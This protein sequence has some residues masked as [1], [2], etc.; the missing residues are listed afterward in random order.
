LS[1]T[2]L[3]IGGTLTLAAF[4][5]RL[6]SGLQPWLSFFLLIVVGA[7]TIVLRDLK[8]LYSLSHKYTSSKNEN[9]IAEDIKQLAT[10]SPKWIILV[11]QAAVFM[12]LV[13]LIG[14]FLP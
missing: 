8:T 9:S 12:S 13:L 11:S 6:A 10:N 7:N 14:K 1:I 5:L 3:S 2:L 4:F